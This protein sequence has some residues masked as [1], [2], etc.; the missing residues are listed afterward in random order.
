MTF[1][2]TTARGSMQAIEWRVAGDSDRGSD[3]DSDTG[4]EMR[5]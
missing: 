5:S 2:R 3:S 4:Y 1:E